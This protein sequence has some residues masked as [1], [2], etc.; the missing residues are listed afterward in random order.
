MI[1]VHRQ[2]EKAFNDRQCNL[3]T[4]RRR[5][6]SIRLS[7]NFN[8]VSHTVVDAEPCNSRGSIPRTRMGLYDTSNISDLSV[9]GVLRLANQYTPLSPSE[10]SDI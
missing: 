9:T 1:L 8:G 10:L 2:C 4:V 6:N 3:D 7:V 5:G